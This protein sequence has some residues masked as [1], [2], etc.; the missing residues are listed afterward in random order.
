MTERVTREAVTS[1][2][3]AA[4]EDARS[5]GLRVTVVVTDDAGVPV[6]LTRMTGARPLSV[7]LATRKALTAARTGRATHEWA[8]MLEDDPA[9]ARAATTSLPDLVLFGGGVPVR[10][11]G[12]ITGAVGVSGASQEDDQLLA[13]RL[14][15]R[16]MPA[17]TDDRGVRP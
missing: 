13:E 1:A 8:R 9:L 6:H 10:E 16:L 5:R 14:A 12:A 7:D 17:D 4:V 3:D 2:V 15:Q 11:G